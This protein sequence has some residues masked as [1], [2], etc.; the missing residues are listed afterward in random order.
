[1]PA[2]QPV[3]F[4]CASC[5]TPLKA[6]PALAGRDARCPHCGV[7]FTVP[8]PAGDTSGTDTDPEMPALIVPN[9]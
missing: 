3:R 2:A 9:E 8:S 1:M 5:D 6:T 7:K 4:P